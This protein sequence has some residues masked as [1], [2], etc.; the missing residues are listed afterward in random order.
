MSKVLKWLFSVILTAVVVAVV[1][2][3]FYMNTIVAGQIEKFGSASLKAKVELG[4]ANVSLFPLG[5]KLNKLSIDKEDKNDPMKRFYADEILVSV[6]HN[7]LRTDVPI[8]NYITV[9]SPEVTYDVGVLG[10]VSGAI[11]AMKEGGPLEAITSGFGALTDG[12]KSLVGKDEEPKKVKKS[13]NT[14][15]SNQKF[16]I[17]KI[18]INSAKFIPVSEKPLPKK[19]KEITLPDIE[20]EFTSETTGDKIIKNVFMSLQR[21][22]LKKFIAG[23]YN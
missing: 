3:H 2:L 8:I 17:K 19:V 10:S 6:D 13:E 9:N 15:G 14:S 7:S 5:I 12:I 1:V 18:Y 23:E 16:V 22:A 21:E 4:S 11:E 20:T